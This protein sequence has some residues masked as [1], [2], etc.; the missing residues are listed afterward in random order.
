MVFLAICLALYCAV[1]MLFVGTEFGEATFLG[2]GILVVFSL[3][4][5]F[6]ALLAPN[7]EAEQDLLPRKLQ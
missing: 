4:S 1:F 5:F 2:A 7:P 3:I 6:V